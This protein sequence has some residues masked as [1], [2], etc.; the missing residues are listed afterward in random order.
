ML[1]LICTSPVLPQL[2]SVPLTHSQTSHSKLQNSSPLFVASLLAKRLSRA[3]A[4][5]SCSTVQLFVRCWVFTEGFVTLRQ[6]P[7]LED[8]TPF[9][10][11][12][13]AHSIH[14]QR[15][16]TSAALGGAMPLCQGQLAVIHLSPRLV[17]ILIP[18][19]VASAAVCLIQRHH[20][21]VKNTCTCS[22]A[23]IC[24]VYI[25]V[26]RR[27]LLWLLPILLKCREL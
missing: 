11:S 6:T 12:A 22:A 24:M 26:R 16:S 17:N 15:F 14:S 7:N 20:A 25:T 4:L 19:T 5:F 13:T 18:S 23:L 8:H 21:F 3:G 1:H 27:V 10:L 2:P 9:R